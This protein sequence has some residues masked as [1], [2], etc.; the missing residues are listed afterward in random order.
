[1]TIKMRNNVKKD[2]VE[3]QKMC[4]RLGMMVKGKP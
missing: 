1:M 3:N 2:D 4:K